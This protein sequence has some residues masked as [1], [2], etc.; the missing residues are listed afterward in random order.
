MF[1]A[2]VLFNIVH[3]G[4]I[5]PGKEC[6]FPSRKER[7]AMGKQHVWGRAQEFGMSREQ[8]LEPIGNVEARHGMFGRAERK[9]HVS[10][11]Y[12]ADV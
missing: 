12:L 6:D 11:G 8:G 5:M 3:P 1:V 7:K 9:E 10:V 2:L 4:R